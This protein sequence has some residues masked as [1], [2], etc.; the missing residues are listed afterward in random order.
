MYAENC[1]KS[2][3]K[4]LLKQLWRIVMNCLEKSIVL[5]PLNE[6]VRALLQISAAPDLIFLSPRRRVSRIWI[7]PGKMFWMLGRT[8]MPLW[9]AS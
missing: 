2:V 6:K 5:P 7:Q 4:R 8:S 9:A 1:D 3:L